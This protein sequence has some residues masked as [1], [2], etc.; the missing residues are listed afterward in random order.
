MYNYNWSKIGCY[1]GLPPQQVIM[2]ARKWGPWPK[3][4]VESCDWLLKE[5]Q[6]KEDV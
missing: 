1:F 4:Q 2:E 6:G 5:N 3:K